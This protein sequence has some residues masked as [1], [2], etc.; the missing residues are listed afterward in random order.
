L[1]WPSIHCDDKARLTFVAAKHSAIDVAWTRQ[2]C[3]DSAALSSRPL[4]GFLT[5]QVGFSALFHIA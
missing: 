4:R 1:V 5:M 2:S 3:N